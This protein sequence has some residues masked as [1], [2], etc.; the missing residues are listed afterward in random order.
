MTLDPRYLIARDTD[1]VD[2]DL[3]GDRHAV[4]IEWTDGQKP[5]SPTRLEQLAGE[6]DTASQIE[7]AY[8]K[9][10]AGYRW[11]TASV[12]REGL[13]RLEEL[14]GAQQDPLVAR[15]E[16]AQ[17]LKLPRQRR[18]AP[19]GLPD[20]LRRLAAADVAGKPPRPPRGTVRDVLAVIDFGCPF[21]HPVLLTGAGAQRST[22][23]RAIWDQ[24]PGGDP[25]LRPSGFS[26]GCQL[27]RRQL[28]AVIRATRGDEA[29][30]YRLVG[31]EAM[32]RRRSHGAHALGMLLDDGIRPR[33]GSDGDPPDVL[34]VQLPQALLGAP[35]RAVLSRHVI[36]ALI[37][38]QAQVGEHERVILS[39]G[40][41]SS[42]GPNDGS[43]MVERALHAFTGWGP[44]QDAKS[45]VLD[46]NRVYIAAGNDRGERL[47]AATKLAARKHR[48]LT[49]RVPPASELPATV[50]L[51]IPE[52]ADGNSVHVSVTDPS[53]T[54]VTV[55]KPGESVH[56]PAGP[57]AE[58]SIAWS[59]W[60]GRHATLCLVRLAPTAI[61]AGPARARA[62]D[63]QLHLDANH[64]LPHPVHLYIGRVQQALGFPLRAA[65]SRFVARQGTGG[66]GASERGTLQ[67][68]ASADGV[69]RVGGY[70]GGRRRKPARYSGQGPSRDA[71]VSGPDLQV[72][73]D[74]GHV[75]KGRRSI[76]N[77]AGITFRMDGTSVAAPL[78]ANLDRATPHHTDPP[79]PAQA[80]SVSVPT[81]PAHSAQAQTG[82]APPRR[83]GP[84]RR[85]DDRFDEAP[86]GKLPRSRRG[87]AQGTGSG[88]S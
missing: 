46:R 20:G 55:T 27:S 24:Q 16:Y 13:Q 87:K 31:Y 63:W 33:V 25:A 12:T 74:S 41:G 69:I 52:Q 39:L 84:G 3:S 61:G 1:F 78:A 6:L 53:G 85:I 34:F 72:K 71:R 58:L 30:G 51:W 9:A 10:P 50:E 76:G 26:Y 7:S 83:P 35:S 22:R 21:M 36:D 70:V 23:V 44:A 42:Q 60:S 28:E 77:R 49:W 48:T 56:R 80:P 18:L 81:G 68:L 57:A 40:Q 82:P 17:S 79:G 73:V 4:I 5:S 29:N 43:S 14:M 54:R 15:F 75:L 88:K 62:G 66:V 38:I 8:F 45:A 59:G 32:R 37:W 2:H 65:Q 64:D 11:A 86:V 67:G 47:H 19:L